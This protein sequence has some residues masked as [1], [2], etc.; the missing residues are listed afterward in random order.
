MIID[1]LP[2]L[3]NRTS[4]LVAL[5]SI[6]WYCILVATGEYAKWSY[7]IL[8]GAAICKLTSVATSIR[9]RWENHDDSNGSSSWS[10]F[11]NNTVSV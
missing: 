7:P 5:I 3:L 11:F 4:F 1:A 6:A 2:R 10:S 8:I 9:P